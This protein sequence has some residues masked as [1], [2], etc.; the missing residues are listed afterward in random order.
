[1]SSSVAQPEDSRS[2]AEEQRKEANAPPDFNPD[3]DLIGWVNKTLFPKLERLGR[4]LGFRR[5]EKDQS[6]Q[7]TDAARPDIQREG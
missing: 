6:P 4:F 2:K 1:V 7:I 5:S 3:D